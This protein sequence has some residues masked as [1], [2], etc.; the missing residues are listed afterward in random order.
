M[1]FDQLLA[2]EWDIIPLNG[3][4]DGTTYYGT[5]VKLP[6]GATITVW[7]A[8]EFKTASSREIENGWDHAIE[9]FDHVEQAE[10]LQIA[11]LIAKAP[12]LYKFS[13]MMLEGWKTHSLCNQPDCLV[14]SARDAVQAIEAEGRARGQKP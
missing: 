5:V 1:T 14:C 8:D 10:D 4:Y 9:G 13:Q 2:K 6:N 11:L 12:A 7:I 3:K